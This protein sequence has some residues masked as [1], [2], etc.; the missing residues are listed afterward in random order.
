MNT[1]TMSKNKKN[2]ITMRVSD[3]LNKS[4]EN[5]SLEMDR[6]KSYLA[7]QALAEFVSERAWLIK[8]A[9]IGLKDVEKGDVISEKEMDV[10]FKKLLKKHK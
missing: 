4:L 3:S 9:K 6:S 8:E 1:S 2:V 10:F 5:L 7:E